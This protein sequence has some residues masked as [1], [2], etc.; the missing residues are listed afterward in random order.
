M[1]KSWP[2]SCRKVLS[3]ILRQGRIIFLDMVGCLASTLIKDNRNLNT[4]CNL[5]S[6]N[7]KEC[8]TEYNMQPWWILFSNNAIRMPVATSCFLDYCHLKLCTST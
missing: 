4:T 3:M 6:H 1:N 2:K 7:A 8:K 5:A